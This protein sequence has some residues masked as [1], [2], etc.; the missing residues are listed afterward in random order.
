MKAFA[1]KKEKPTCCNFQG[2]A[3]RWEDNTNSELIEVLFDHQ[4]STHTRTFR[5]ISLLFRTEVTKYQFYSLYTID[6]FVT[7]ERQALTTL[8][9]TV[10]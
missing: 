4:D 7:E 5:H 8:Q 9:N 2:L 6:L 1:S 10:V 3:W